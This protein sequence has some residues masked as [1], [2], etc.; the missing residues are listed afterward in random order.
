MNLKSCCETQCSGK[1]FWVVS[2]T[3]FIKRWADSNASAGEERGVFA[4]CRGGRDA[5]L[6]VGGAGRFA[7]MLEKL[8]IG[9]L[10]CFDCLVC[11]YFF[12]FLQLCDQYIGMRGFRANTDNRYRFGCFSFA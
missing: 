12:M 2:V 1:R 10:C 11:F 6:L 9:V 3:T 8:D 7:V 4:I 5:S